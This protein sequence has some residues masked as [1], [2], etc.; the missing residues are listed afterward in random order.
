M[1]QVGDV[2]VVRPVIG[3][4]DKLAITGSIKQLLYFNIISSSW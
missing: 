4:V 3:W 2:L 1:G